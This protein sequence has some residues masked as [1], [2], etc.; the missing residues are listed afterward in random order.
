MASDLLR[1]EEIEAFA[2]SHPNPFDLLLDAD[3]ASLLDLGA[4][5]LSFA[6]ELVELCV[7]PF[8]SDS[9]S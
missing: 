3:V 9:A 2:H 6:T 4:G 7:A 5:D 8:N 1:S